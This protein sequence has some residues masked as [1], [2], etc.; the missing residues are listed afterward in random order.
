MKKAEK[1]LNSLDCCKIKTESIKNTTRSENCVKV[2]EKL[3]KY[4]IDLRK[5]Y[6]NISE[7]NQKTVELHCKA[8]RVI[9]DVNASIGF[10]ASEKLVEILK[11]NFDFLFEN[12]QKSK[13]DFF[14][15]LSSMEFS[16][17]LLKDIEELK[18]ELMTQISKN[19]VDV[20]TSEKCQITNEEIENL[21]FEVWNEFTVWD[22]VWEKELTGIFEEMNIKNEN[23]VKETKIQFEKTSI[24]MTE[25]LNFLKI[26]QEKTDE[27]KKKFLAAKRKLKIHSLQSP[28][29]GYSETSTS[30]LIQELKARKRPLEENK[31]EDDFC[32]SKKSK[33]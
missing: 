10:L 26:T 19:I 9:K 33:M 28:Y 3:V 24:E 1:C 22:N 2:A 29:F 13:G 6:A 30:S 7:I 15:N 27:S 20:L 16:I 17:S 23:E 11:E 5:I 8:L 14:E 18:N 31:F 12:I 4:C 21:T 25:K 32:F